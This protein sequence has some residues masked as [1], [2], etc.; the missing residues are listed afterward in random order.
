MRALCLLA[1]T[2][3]VTERG[4]MDRA[5][6]AVERGRMND[7]PAWTGPD[8]FV[9]NGSSRAHEKKDCDEGLPGA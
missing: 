7:P 4:S 2:R 1:R 3:V 9:T 8:S 5:A 6:D